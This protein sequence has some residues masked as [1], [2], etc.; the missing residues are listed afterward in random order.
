MIK[1]YKIFRAIL[2]TLLIMGVG[3]PVGLYV[4]MSTPW[5][6]EKLRK[7][8]EEE[9][10]KLLGTEV[11]IGHVGFTP[12]DGIA[13]EKVNVKDDYKRD[14]L[15][16][17]ELSLR[18]ELAYFLKKGRLY[19]DY[20][21]ING[22]DAWLYKPTADGKLNIANI[23]E[24]LK[25][26]DKT[27]P[28]T[29]FELAISTV[30]IKNSSF[31]YD[32]LDA[33][34]REHGLDVKHIKLSQLELN[35]YLPKITD[36]GVSAQISHLSF[37]EQSGL[38][39][40]DFSAEATVL[41]GNVSL[42]N[43]VLEL[44][45]SRIALNSFEFAPEKLGELAELGRTKPVAASI[46]EG[47]HLT[48]SDLAW[49]VPAFGGVDRCF[50]IALEAHGILND[51][52]LKRLY[53]N[54]RGGD[55]LFV[56]AAGHV[57]G[58]PK[59]D[60]MYV[61]NLNLNLRAQGKSVSGLTSQMAKNI[62]PKV[63][64]MLN[65][66]G[67]IN[68]KAEASGGL[69]DIVGQVNLV[70]SLGSIDFDGE[71]HIQPATKH[72]NVDAR[73]NVDNFD[74]GRLL[75]DS[76]LGR[77]SLNVEGNAN[78]AGK[79]TDAEGALLVETFEF[80]GNNYHDISLEGAYRRDKSFEAT[81]AMDNEFGL[82]KLEGN[83]SFKRGDEQ[84]VLSTVIRDLD[85]QALGARGSY[86]GYHLNADIDADLSGSIMDW[87]NGHLSL[88]NISFL[89]PAGSDR[90]SLHIKN[91]KLVA[92]NFERPATLKLSSDFINGTL[93]GD[94]C[95]RTLGADIMSTVGKV[96]P[97]FMPV[98]KT[99]SPNGC[100]ARTNNF[101][102]GFEIANAEELCRFFKLP[103]QI[104]YPV[105]ID[106]SVDM[107]K[108]S[109][110]LSLDAPWLF[111]GDKIIENTVLQLT[112]DGN[113]DASAMLYATSQMPTKKGDMALVGTFSAAQNRVDTRVDWMLE[114]E[115]PINGILSF[116]TLL[117]KD[118][119][120]GLTAD[121][122]FN[123]CDI[124]FGA[125]SWHIAPSH[126][127]YRRNNISVNDF[128]MSSG[129]QRIAIEGDAS[130]HSDSRLSLDLDK[131]ELISI[132]ETLDINK[133][134]IGGRATGKFNARALLS[135]QPEINCDHLHVDSI[136][137]NYCVLG[138]ADVKARW[139]NDTKSVY[140]DADVIEPEGEH[141]HIYGSITPAE[142]ALDINFDANK[143]RVGFLKPFMSAFADD[144]KGH[145]SGH[146]RLFGTFKYID[147]EGDIYA[148]DFGL[149]VGFTNTW[150][151]CTDSVHLSPG[152]IMIDKAKVR[153]INGNTAKL[154]GR[155][156][157][158]FFKDPT[159]DFRLTDAVNFLSYDV[160][161]KLSPDWYGRIYGNGSAF[162]SGEPGVV[163]IDVNMSTAPN[164]TFTFVLSD[165]EEAD[166]Y[167]FISFRDR[168]AGVIKDSI[169]EVDRIPQIVR[170]HQQR[171]AK[172][173]ADAPTDYNMNIQVDITPQ[174]NIIV[175]MDPV[176]GDEIKSNGSGSLRMTYHSAG[177]DLRMYGTY[178]IERGSY[179]F[180]LQDIIVKDFKIKDG[181][182]IAFTGDPYS[183]R[184][185]IQAIYSVNANL[186]DLD[187]SFLQDKE[188]NRTNVP[189]NA[190]LKVNGDMRQP[191]ISFDLEFP[192]LTS[193][194]YRKVRSIVSTDEMM[195]RQ[196]IYLL[197][198]GRFYTPE[199]MSTTKG[200]ELFSVASSTIGS[201][202]TSMLGKLS[203]NWTI[204]P[205]LRSDKGDF[206]DVEFDLAL[207][208]SLLNNRLRLNGNFGYR[209]KSLNTNQFI[210]DFDIEY[211]L[212]RSGSW[213]LKA[214]NRYNDQNYYLRTAQTTQG[215]GIMFKRDFDKMFNFLRRKK[216]PT[217]EADDTKGKVSDETKDAEK[218]EGED[219]Q[220]STE[221]K[222]ATEQK[223]T[224]VTFRTRVPNEPDSRE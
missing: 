216:K 203:D 74:M 144:V 214:Y 42:K 79:L 167:T 121:I 95:L 150:F 63:T 208:S 69:R 164:S 220:N 206:S 109:I 72:A 162:I 85:I 29:K 192:T 168:N 16:I 122:D 25:P 75:A 47:S 84:L 210:G 188:L 166:E 32:I 136:S 40:C 155:V 13:L 28:P 182:S 187:E 102:Y 200:N 9:L 57:T 101:H 201:R 215:V 106:G 46:L 202:L 124:T 138:N 82:I 169:I 92:D 161:P 139:D 143:V 27:K 65:A 170:E 87:V 98:S 177:N 176:G 112:V 146:A 180:T 197:A 209:D 129:D 179:N 152:N 34:K 222:D 33:P 15:K 104:I 41:P 17:D 135:K 103:V 190:L 105:N 67:D 205:N 48:L 113:E 12:F 23:I 70:C 110:M 24:H 53:V 186:S 218:Q 163:N 71:A 14:A 172:A 128:V 56:D 185:D 50:D 158:K 10:S 22:M 183:A 7:I 151:F 8:G 58:L 149:K 114:R 111:N 174:A 148:H 184:L 96:L 68:L 194:T 97:V 126:I 173:N 11:S 66:L 19:F 3:I 80:K 156:T 154:T 142:E 123:P 4:V 26:K 108:R 141:S 93:E 52:T 140:L 118:E 223:D 88:S 60:S 130:D 207:S 213:R 147:L 145:A 81:L 211:L 175:V 45:K 199:Y 83:G 35:A 5:A 61:E 137:Y 125:D 49:A 217:I 116:S 94:V 18:F 39:V 20:A 221:Q 132:F 6:Q 107:T 37:K 178:T 204:A 76:R 165:M 86:E 1:A 195:N 193:D 51:L 99:P 77:V 89:A 2:L 43:P 191:D 127:A 64:A 100:V 115:K 133:A 159:F 38:E 212:N 62:P 196:I 73:V 157:H 171:L 189:V 224:V 31:R 120:N 91:I 30:E 219:A 160:T 78:I 59:P 55:M 131:I 21:A 54:E 198:L 134:L 119:S 181:S 36:E 90:P 153:D 117:G 44:P